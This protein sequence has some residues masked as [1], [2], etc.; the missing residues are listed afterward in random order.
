MENNSG[1]KSVL[2]KRYDNDGKSTRK[3]KDSQM[4]FITQINKKIRSK[5][6]QFESISCTICKSEDFD[7]LSEKDK[8]GLLHSVKICKECGLVQTNPRLTQDSYAKFYDIEYRASGMGKSLSKEKFFLRQKKRGWRIHSYLEKILGHS[9]ENKFIVEIGTGAGGI[10]Q[11]FKEKNNRVL[12]IDLGSEYIKYGKSM[13]LDLKTGTI[14]LLE[15]EK[16]KPDIVIYSHVLEHTTNPVEDLKKLKR[17]LTSNSI[18]YIEVPGIKFLDFSY[19]QD[20]LEYLNFAHT[21]HFTL[22]TL[23]NC[24]KK[25]GF[26]MINGNEVVIALFRSTEQNGEQIKSDYKQTMEYLKKLEFI[27][28]KKISIEKMKF[29][30]I[31]TITKILNVTKTREPIELFYYKLKS[32]R[33]S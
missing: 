2:G 23:N 25:A 28:T 6:Y 17:H 26:N 30:V 7:I 19:K 9:I 31:R 13:G 33:Y 10:L 11:F 12:G 27:R 3:I 16:Q 5:E 1:N 21:Y 8:F 15:N 14:D 20:F 4:K 29:Y 24:L 18:V 22:E 32:E